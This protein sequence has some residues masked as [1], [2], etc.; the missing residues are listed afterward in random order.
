MIKMHWNGFYSFTKSGKNWEKKALISRIDWLKPKQ[1]AWK[2]SS[3]TE[4]TVIK[5][6]VYPWYQY[7]VFWNYVAITYLNNI[8]TL[9]L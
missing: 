3:V 4:I 8:Y 7:Q 1:N 5:A 2:D 9:F 6:Y